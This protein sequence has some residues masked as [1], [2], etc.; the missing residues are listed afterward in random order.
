[1]NDKNC[2]GSQIFNSFKLIKILAFNRDQVYIFR[3]TLLPNDLDWVKNNGIS[4]QTYKIN[5]RHKYGLVV[6]PAIIYWNSFEF[7]VENE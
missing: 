6:K 3:N 4:G 1:M 2:T 7:G 5:T